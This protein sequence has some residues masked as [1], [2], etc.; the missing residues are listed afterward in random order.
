[1]KTKYE[2]LDDLTFDLEIAFAVDVNKNVE[3]SGVM[4][5]QRITS[6]Y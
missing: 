5:T 6:L 4:H 1:L 3:S 2:L